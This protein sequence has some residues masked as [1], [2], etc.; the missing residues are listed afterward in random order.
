M[1]I[2]KYILEYCVVMFIKDSILY[3]QYTK[4][5]Y[6]MKYSIKHRIKMSFVTIVV[7]VESIK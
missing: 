6:I 3:T 4:F 1:I 5:F 2:F 7:A